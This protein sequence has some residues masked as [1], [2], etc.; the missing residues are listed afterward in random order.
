MKYIYLLL[1]FFSFSSAAQKY[2]DNHSCNECHEK[3]YEEFQSSMH[4]KGYFT[5]TLHRKIADKVSTKTYECARCHMPM[6]NNMDALLK[7]EAR[8][9]KNNKTHTDAISCYFCH[10]IAYVKT[11]HKFNI[12]TKSKQAAN[13]KPTLYGRL[14]NPDKSDKHSSV[15]NPIYAK[16]VCTGCHSHKL[17]DNN[18]TV[19]RAMRKGEDSLACI[20]CHMPEVSG[21]VEKMDKRAR[22]Q[23]ASHTFLGIHDKAFR[24]KGVDLNVSVEKETLKVTLTNKMGH[25]LII[26]PA[27]AKFLKI[28]VTR[29]GKVIWQNFKQAPKEDAQGYFAYRFAKEGHP[30]IIPAEA[31][32]GEAHNLAAKETKVLS[33][34][35]P[36][37]QK[38]DEITVGLYVQ[39]AKSDC[40]RVIDLK[41][42]SLTTPQLIKEVKTV[43][44]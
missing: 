33:Y 31:T 2:L 12:N 23:H 21:G 17:N 38:S 19:F 10:T 28:T 7:G 35:L 4:A 27:R 39:L 13:Y 43:L 36:K 14:H 6:A 3:I 34:T 16:K 32:H 44:P 22:G 18:V 25:P 26:Q 8:P 9:D 41:D 24:K 37:L 15:N 29:G 5:D 1:F 20:K 42:T 40:A 30:L 11:A